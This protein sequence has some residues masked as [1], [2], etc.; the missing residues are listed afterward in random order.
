MENMI[1]KIEKVGNGYSAHF[2]RKLNHSVEDVWAMLTE[3]EQ[4]K[5][6]FN[7]L[8]VGELR[9]GGFMK[10][11]VPDVMNEELKIFE[12][13]PFSVVEFDWFGDV[14]RFELHAKQNGCV[15]ILKETINTLTE[16]TRK[17]LAGWHVCLDVIKALL[18]GETIQREIEWKKWH[19]KY[20]QALDKFI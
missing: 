5:K 8:R 4:L 19:E 13:K 1:A 20:I 16:Q 9:E 11:E 3:N 15:L 18:D 10:F 14:V 7:E 12:F 17:D 6:W 2:E